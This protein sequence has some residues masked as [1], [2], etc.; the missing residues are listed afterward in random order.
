[1][2]KKFPGVN[3]PPDTEHPMIA[4]AIVLVSGVVLK[5]TQISQLTAFMGYSDEFVLA[6]AHNVSQNKLWTENGYDSK[7][8]SRWVFSEKAH[9]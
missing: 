9:T 2:T 4:V 7:Q 1:M 8:V 5:T 3:D 6:I